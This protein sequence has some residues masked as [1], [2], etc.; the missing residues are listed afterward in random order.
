MLSSESLSTRS[1]SAL[2]MWYY[3][4]SKRPHEI[5]PLIMALK[6]KHGKT[7][8]LAHGHTGSW[9]WSPGSHAMCPFIIVVN[10]EYIVTVSLKP[11]REMLIS[12]IVITSLSLFVVLSSKHLLL[13]VICKFYFISEKVE[14]YILDD[15]VSSTI[16]SARFMRLIHFVACSC[17]S[18]VSL[19]CRRFSF[20]FYF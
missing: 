4:Y 20:I 3:Q 14:K 2:D 8:Q 7:K 9:D 17:V 18:F 1:C 6:F 5:D 19:L 15:V 16:Y 13:H 11:V 12:F 10:T